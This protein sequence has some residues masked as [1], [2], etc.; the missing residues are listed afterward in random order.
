MKYFQFIL[1]FIL[2]VTS[3]ALMGNRNSFS[4][5]AGR[6]A[7]RARVSGSP[8]DDFKDIITMKA[9]ILKKFA[10]L[11][12]FYAVMLAPIYG[13]GFP[14]LGSMT[15]FS[16]LKNRCQSYQICNEYIVAPDGFTP[17]RRD[18]T[19]AP[20]FDLP[21]DDLSKVVDKVV[22]RQPRVRFIAKDEPTRR[23]E[24]VQRTLIFR[25]P[26]PVTFQVIPLGEKKSTL[27]VHSY[28]VY[29]AGDLGVNGN[30][31]RT[32]LAEIENEAT[33]K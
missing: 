2:A 11:L 8:L 24:Y 23:Q 5:R 33:A 19:P 28:S 20:V 31:V 4:K 27:A 3:S 21:A 16:T 7:D 22:M 13:I 14:G 30:R 29:G 10:P 15:D 18:A 6:D 1:I 17:A 9:G 26:D 12:G 25:F 32:W